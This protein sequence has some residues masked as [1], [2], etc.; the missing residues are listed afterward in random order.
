MMAYMAIAAGLGGALDHALAGGLSA[1]GAWLSKQPTAAIPY[2]DA[3]VSGAWV[4]LPGG[5]S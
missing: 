3:M 2:A 1:A 4:N 5:G